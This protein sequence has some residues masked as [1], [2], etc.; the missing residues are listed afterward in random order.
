[1]SRILVLGGGLAAA[2]ALAGC[3]GLGR[4]EIPKEVPVPTPVSCIRPEDVPARPVVRTDAELLELDTYR[5]THAL[6]AAYQRFKAYAGEL[7]PIAQGCSRIP[8]AT[9]PP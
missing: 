1:M 9:P 5:F 3:G 8:P 4:V 2:L 7:E 6:W